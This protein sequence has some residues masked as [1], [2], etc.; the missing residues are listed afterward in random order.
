MNC[1]S[2]LITSDEYAE[3]RKVSPKTLANKRSRKKGIRYYKIGG[4][5][6]YHLDDVEREESESVIETVHPG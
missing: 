4:K 1:Q 2:R 5:V 6:Y 3:R